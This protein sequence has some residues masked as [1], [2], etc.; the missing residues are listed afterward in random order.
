MGTAELVSG[1][2]IIAIKNAT[3]TNDLMVFFK[4]FSPFSVTKGY[5]LRL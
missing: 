5:F 2:A 3:I 4:I 1:I